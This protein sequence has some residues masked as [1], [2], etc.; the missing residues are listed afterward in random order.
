MPHPPR[1]AAALVLAWLLAP[2]P[3]AADG[4]QR[5]GDWLMG[6]TDTGRCTLVGLP[7]AAP[8]TTRLALRIEVA[9]TAN[10]AVAIEAIPLDDR[11]LPDGG[12]SVGPFPP[13]APAPRHILP[14]SRGS[15]PDDWAAAWLA[16]L[17]RGDPLA[18]S[19]PVR[20]PDPAGFRAAWMA[21]MRARLPAPQALAM[22]APHPRN[23]LAPA[24]EALPPAP[25]PGSPCAGALRQFDLPGGGRLW[26]IACAGARLHWFGAP[27]GGQ[28]AP[29][30]LP[31]GDRPARAAGTEGLAAS[32][33]DFDFGVLRAQDHPAGREDCGT[34]R[35]WAWDG[36]G[37]FLLARREMP[38]CAGL[39]TSAWVATHGAP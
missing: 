21:L 25:L 37:W 36:A 39:D 12:V 22:H 23:R 35:A 17:L 7:M 33:F 16:Q 5:H 13:D 19:P 15:L 6:C 2:A 28:P 29:L 14:R 24:I 32:V 20:L 38:V 27:P 11:P 26:S 4:L 30:A 34:I 8:G 18:A 31:D 9:A 1:L 10:A 3:G